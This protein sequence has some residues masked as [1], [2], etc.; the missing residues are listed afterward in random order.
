MWNMLVV[1]NG[2]CDVWAVFDSPPILVGVA[3]HFFSVKILEKW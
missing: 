1:K 2:A 3:Q